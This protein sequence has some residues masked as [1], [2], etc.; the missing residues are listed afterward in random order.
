M[1]RVLRGRGS[2]K[3]KAGN[4]SFNY[5]RGVT[6]PFHTPM[7]CVTF[8]ILRLDRI[9]DFYQLGVSIFVII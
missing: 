2:E 9:S 3:G 4:L 5:K 8:S 7:H 6:H 1:Q